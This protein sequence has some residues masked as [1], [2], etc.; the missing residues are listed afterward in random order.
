VQA[1]DGAYGDKVQVTWTASSGATGYRVF[2]NTSN[3][4]AGAVQIADVS[5]LF[6]DDTA[7]DPMTTYWYWVG[8]Y[9]NARDSALSDADTGYR[10]SISL[11]EAVDEPSLRIRTGG[12]A[13]WAVDTNEFYYDA[14]AAQS[15]DISDN[16]ESWMQTA[17]TVP[18]DWPLADLSFYWKVSSEKGCDWL[19]FYIDSGLQHRISGLVDWQKKS[20]TLSAGSHTLKWRYIK[21]DGADGGS[22]CGWVDKLECV[23][24]PPPDPP[25]QDGSLTDLRQ[26]GRR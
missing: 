8:A 25:N 18:D 22:D 13:N 10:R 3:S 16:Q 17:V 26:S 21:D 9:N 5:Y 7:A 23:G 15:G 14:G 4:A 6:Y 2:R 20:Y 11:S 24:P 19:E 12:G 1:S